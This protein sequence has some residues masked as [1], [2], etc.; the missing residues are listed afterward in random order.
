MSNVEII[1]PNVPNMPWQERPETIR[2]NF[3]FGDIMKIRLLEE[4]RQKELQE[5]S[6]VQLCHKDGFIGVFRGETD[7]RSSIYLS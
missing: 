1:G 6:T 5:S 7:K 4:I 3:H 2:Q